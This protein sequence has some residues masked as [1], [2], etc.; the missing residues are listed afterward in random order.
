LK[1]SCRALKFFSKS[2]KIAFSSLFLKVSTIKLTGGRSSDRFLA[3]GMCIII[4]VLVPLVFC[5][6]KDHQIGLVEIREN[7]RTN[8]CKIQVRNLEAW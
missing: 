4:H 1:E 2:Q 6:G 7:G 3:A 8:V 5:L